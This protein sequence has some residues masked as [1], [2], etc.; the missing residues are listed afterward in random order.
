MHK[1]KPVRVQ[2]EARY[3]Q[4]TR[5]EKNLY[6]RNVSESSERQNARGPWTFIRLVKTVKRNAS[7]KPDFS[8]SSWIGTILGKGAYGSVFAAKMTRAL[9]TRLRE[10]KMASI[11][12]LEDSLPPPESTVCIKLTGDSGIYKRRVDNFVLRN[13]KEAS[14]HRHLST[15]KPIEL[16]GCTTKINIARHVPKFYRTEMVFDLVTRSRWFVTLMGKAKGMP[17][18]SVLKN[19]RG[20]IPASMYVRIEFAIVSAWLY[21]IAHADVHMENVFYHTE[22]KTATLLDFGFA[23]LLTPALVH[24]LRDAIPRAIRGGV[25]SLGE[26]WMSPAQS[27]FGTDALA[28]VNRVQYKRRPSRMAWYNPDGHALMSLYSRVPSKERASVVTERMRVWGCH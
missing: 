5:N 10:V 26:V 20:W 24:K 4:N 8:W 3:V 19:T 11:F 16:D 22:S 13:L 23:T 28:Y 9:A 17:L 7:G 6:L 18:S 21:G 25:R 12:W 14:F 15:S 2:R 27:E 1:G